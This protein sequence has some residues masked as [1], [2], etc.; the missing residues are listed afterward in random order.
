VAFVSPTLNPQ[1][2]GVPPAGY[3][4][5]LIQ[6]WRTNP[7]LGNDRETNNEST[8]VLGGDP[9][10]AMEVLL[11]A[12]FSV[13]RSKATSRDRPSSVQWSEWVD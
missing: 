8:A 6:Q 1:D 2:G 12:V 7:L 13:V 9:R 11:I 4:R 5:L 10:A 3:P